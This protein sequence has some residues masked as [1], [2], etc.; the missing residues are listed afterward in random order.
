MTQKLLIVDD[1]INIL[2]VISTALRKEGFLVDTSLSGED[3]IERLNQT[4][5][6]LIVSD[7]KLPGIDGETL[8]GE[9]RARY[10]SAPIILLTAFGT[11]EL[12][13]TA[14]KKGAY[15]YLTKLVNLDLLITIIKE[16][17]MTRDSDLADGEQE[18]NQFLNIVGKSNAVH[19]VFSMIRRVSKTDANVL[20]TGESGT[21]KELVARAIHYN[22]LKSGGPFIPLDC[23]TIPEELV[24]SELF[25]HEKGAFTC[26]YDNKIGLIEMANGGTI[27]LDEI[28]DLDFSLQKKL[29]RFLQEKEFFRLGGKKTIKVDARVLAATNRNIEDAVEKGDFRSD[30]Y[31]RL[32]VITIH[33]PPLRERRED[34]PLLAREFLDIFSFKNKKEIRGF[35]E[36]VINL[37]SNYD[38]P[39]NV[40]ELENT[41]ERAVILCP[42]DQISHE[43]LP[44]RLK[45]LAGQELSLTE[46][47]NLLATEK[48]IIQRALEKTSWNQTRAAELL[49]I[50]RKQLLTKLKNLKIKTA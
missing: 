18:C 28:G 17:L 11:I 47:F 33:V 2:K 35:D 36:E 7:Y 21:G 34:I 14:M 38:W 27:F 19:E 44:H 25:G 48:R 32:N 31:Y 23:T 41:I 22:S 42:Y 12:A 16:A 8:L 43:S 20:I 45:L 24:E 10:D 1:E 46:E 3:A 37:L 49:G 26:A 29:L 30:L 6:D 9:V 39:G 4:T 5:Y 13:V 15:T 50:S 40:R